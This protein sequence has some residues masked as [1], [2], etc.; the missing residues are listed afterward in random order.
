MIPI[1]TVFERSPARPVLALLILAGGTGLFMALGL[2]GSHWLDVGIRAGLIMW[3]LF[4]ALRHL[5]GLLLQRQQPAGGLATAYGHALLQ[6]C[7]AAAVTAVAVLLLIVDDDSRALLSLIF[8]IL[9]AA[10]A[11][12]G[13]GV[14]TARGGVL[15]PAAVSTDL[16]KG[17]N[18]WNDPTEYRWSCSGRRSC[19]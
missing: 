19:C 9:V 15:G 14:I 12:R 4:Y 2:A 3:L 6:A 18:P 11:A 13:G 7:A 10:A 5:A 8:A 1:I 16:N 17:E